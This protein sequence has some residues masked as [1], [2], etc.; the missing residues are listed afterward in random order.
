MKMNYV[1]AYEPQIGKRL[2]THVLPAEEYDAAR[3]LRFGLE[4]KY[5]KEGR[6]VE[7]VLLQEIGR[8]HV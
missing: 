3:D 2:E 1:I 8:A 5:R 6:D 4:M 7:V